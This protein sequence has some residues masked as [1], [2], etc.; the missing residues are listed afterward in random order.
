MNTVAEIAGNT[1]KVVEAVMKVEP[2][3]V[4]VSSMFVPGMG[5]VA[6]LV[7][8]WVMTVVPYVEKALNDIASSNNTDAF[9]AF[10]ELLQHITKGGP[11]SPVLSAPAPSAS[12]L[13]SG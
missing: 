11:N 4:G 13:G 1:E 7:Q 3:I 5:P 10:I 12:N 9:A 2:T 8:P 6:A